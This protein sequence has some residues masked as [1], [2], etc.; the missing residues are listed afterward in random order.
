MPIDRGFN[1]VLLIFYTEEIE[2]C[3][4]EIKNV[5][6]IS[7]QIIYTITFPAEIKNGNVF[8]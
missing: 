6:E 1:Y 7:E 5:K 3:H 2:N 4:F 8:E